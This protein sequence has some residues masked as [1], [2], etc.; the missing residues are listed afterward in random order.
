MSLFNRPRR[1]VRQD[2]LVANRRVRH[3]KVKTRF[4]IDFRRCVGWVS[5]WR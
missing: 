4:P 3:A 1:I 2:Q 5:G